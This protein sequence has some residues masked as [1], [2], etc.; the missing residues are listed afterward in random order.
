[1]VNRAKRLTGL[2]PLSYLGVEPTSPPQF[3]TAQ[4]NPTS[5]DWQNFDLGTIWLN[6]SDNSIWFLVSLNNNQATWIQLAQANPISGSWTPSLEFGGASVGI[7]YGLQ[8][9]RYTQIGNQVAYT[10][11]IE[12]TSKGSSTGP[13]IVSGFPIAHGSSNLR[14]SSSCTWSEIT[15]VSNTTNVGCYLQN[16]VFTLI[17]QET[18]LAP[19]ALDDTNFSN[20]SALYVTGIMLVD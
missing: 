16:D 17:A 11:N 3:V 13:A 15:Y 10:F 4:R 9:G 12:L 7:T 6:E 1:M 19:V 5:I 14:Y 18:V 8:E 2:N 20:T